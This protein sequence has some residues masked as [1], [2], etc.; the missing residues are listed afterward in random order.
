MSR[1]KRMCCRPSIG[2]FDNLK[3]TSSHPLPSPILFYPVGLG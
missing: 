1:E 3:Y 2:M